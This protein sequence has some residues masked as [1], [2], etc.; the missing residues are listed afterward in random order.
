MSS[1]PVAALNANEIR[2]R[3]SSDHFKM[4][5][6]PVPEELQARAIEALRFGVDAGSDFHVIAVGTSRVEMDRYISWLLNSTIVHLDPCCDW[7]Y[8]MNF[9]E[10][11]RPRAI[12]VPSGEA[13]AFQ[14]AVEQAIDDLRADIPR[15]FEA[16]PYE[17]RRRLLF[18]QFSQRRDAAFEELQEKAA[19]A[20]FSLIQSPTGLGLVPV[21]DGEPMQPQQFS[22]L[23]KEEQD[24]LNSARSGL[25]A[26]LERTLRIIREIET[27]ARQTLRRLDRGIASE[28]VDHR[29]EELRNTYSENSAIIDYLNAMADD[30]VDHLGAFRQQSD[31]DA[32]SPVAQSREAIAA[33]EFFRRYQ[34]NVVVDHHGETSPTVLFEEHPTYGN[35]V[36]R[37]ERRGVMGTL[38]TDFTMIRAGA[39]LK[40]N[41]GFLILDLRDLISAPF[42]WDALKHALERGVVRI[43]ELGQL[44]GT[45]ATTSL[46]PEPIPLDIKVIL[47]A[48][49]LLAAQLGALDPEFSS[50][51]KIR[52]EF[53]STAN[54]DDDLTQALASFLV[55]IR[56]GTWPPL[57]TSGISRVLEYAARLAGDQ[58]RL[59][60]ELEPLSD[61]AREAMQIAGTSGARATTA[62][63]V[64]QAIDARH[65]RA[66]Y[67]AERLREMLIDRTIM[68]DTEGEVVGQINGLTVM[69]QSGYA[70]GTPVR[71]TARSYAGQQG[72]VNI[73]REVELGGPIQSKGVLILAGLLGEIFGRERQL[74][75][76]AS[77]VFEQTYSPVEGD[78]ASLGELCALLSSLSGYPLRQD[79]AVTG[80]I[81]QLGEVQSIGGLNEKIEGF[82]ELCSARELTGTQGVVFPAANAVNLMVRPGVVEAVAAGE[83]HLYPVSTVE[84]AIELFT[85][86]PAGEPGDDGRFPKDSV[87]GRVA[88]R[89]HQ[90]ADATQI[91]LP[92]R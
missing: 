74:S 31:D 49:G 58:R 10:P 46:E 2:W 18:E 71:I 67:S 25:N 43:E 41:Q 4:T 32:A 79:L 44:A 69:A 90:F 82:F 17:E 35:L 77:L 60:V 72:I 64:Q 91:Q 6:D 15:A 75:L 36:G 83:F 22:Q 52:A 29:F 65:S 9:S 62:E 5:A 55:A 68:I 85:G 38:V 28:V 87:F 13:R 34:V 3:C 81:N 39:L 30:I 86:Q 76:S 1:S 24:R 48:D 33:D 59:S 8:V 50:L 78:S 61:L 14:Q 66:L 21:V 27:E 23:P 54:R 92:G 63:F 56:E 84:Q 89:L 40:A 51:F 7:C 45:V 12:Q 37:I 19:E 42:A 73:D 70:F 11:N 26:E 53:Q 20:G 16:E 88:E 57:D 80:S 47:M